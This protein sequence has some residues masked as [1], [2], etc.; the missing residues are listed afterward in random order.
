MTDA[1]EAFLPFVIRPN[2]Y[3]ANELYVVTKAPETVGVQVALAFPD[4]YERG[5]AALMTQTLYHVL[6]RQ[7]NVLAE[8]VFAPWEDMERELR[9]RRLELVTL[10]SHRPLSAFDVIW[11]TLPSAMTY[12]N[13]FTMLDLGDL[14]L[15]S[16]ERGPEAPLIIAGGPAASN[17]EPMAAFVDA[18]AIGDPEAVLPPVLEV[19]GSLRADRTPRHAILR[20]LAEM[21]GVYVP[22]CYFPCERRN[23]GGPVEAQHGF[24]AVVSGRYLAELGP[25]LYPERP[26]VPTLKTMPDRL[27]VEVA[28]GGA[29]MGCDVPT[30]LGP[31]RER[32]PEAVVAQAERNV[33]AGGWEEIALVA[34]VPCT[35][36]ALDDLVVCLAE[37]LATKRVAVA[38]P[39]LLPDAFTPR[40]AEALARTRK[41]P[42][43]LMLQA[44]PGAEPIEADGVVRAAR[45]A[46][47]LVWPGLTLYAS[48]GRPGEDR[49]TLEGLA[50]VTS[51]T[52]E[53][54]RRAG[55]KLVHLVVE[56]S[57]P[58]PC[59]ALEREPLVA[60]DELEQRATMLK[61]QIRGRN[62]R[63]RWRGT[64]ASRVHALLARG[65]RR[66]GDVALAAWQDGARFDGWATHFEFSRWCAAWRTAN[67]DPEP[68]WAGPGPEGPLGWRHIALAP[69]APK[70]QPKGK[71]HPLQ[72]VLPRGE[73]ARDERY[74]RGRRQ[75]RKTLP[76]EVRTMVRVEYSKAGALRFVSH[77]DLVRLFDR[78]TRRAGLPIRYSRGHHPH[79][80]L[81]FGPPLPLGIE[82]E[83]EYFDM[84]LEG[85]LP[86]G[87]VTHLNRALPSGLKV[88]RMKLLYGKVRSLDAAIN[89]AHYQAQLGEHPDELEAQIAA[90]RARSACPVLRTTD[91]GAREIDVRPLVNDLE[92]EPAKTEEG[93]AQVDMWLAVG[94]RGTARPDDVLSAAFGLDRRE[95]ATVMVR[96]VGLFIERD[97][98]RVTPMDVV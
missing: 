32:P 71:V 84:T 55:G 98:L 43:A 74:G 38:L 27:P 90:F 24:P 76:E 13:V 16:A 57:V 94:Q 9:A 89:L 10:E 97:G 19:I 65:D 28:R 12:T 69:S 37:T 11:F 39:P 58:L 42:L 61:R 47:D 66:V 75:R 29:A 5:Q 51:R 25:D 48:L 6:N 87:L 14:P 4:A 36:R 46:F 62:V 26:I 77:L 80:E 86:R 93:T 95:A 79:P 23:G 60:T 33:C 30:P 82:G 34:P 41:T 3:L 21:D 18:F 96:R 15:R 68:Y 17:P 44:G 85:A 49:G 56:P 91:N 73:S 22:S 83:A 54:A 70:T 59:D 81:A 63:L 88:T 67:V 7:P 64:E 52:A 50:Q 72:Q 20:A 1:F 31:R 45:L 35:H 78:A 8:R 92:V 53:I 40:L 2:Q